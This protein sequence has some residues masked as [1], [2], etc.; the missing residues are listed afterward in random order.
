MPIT[1]RKVSR[2][3]RINLSNNEL[4]YQKLLQKHRKLQLQFDKYKDT[5]E[6]KI[7]LLR[8][9]LK[10]TL[11]FVGVKL[12]SLETRLLWYQKQWKHQQSQ[13]AK[14]S[15][16][17]KIQ[18]NKCIQTNM[19]NNESS[20]SLQ[21]SNKSK[22]ISL[23]SNQATKPLIVIPTP[24]IRKPN[25]TNQIIQTPKFTLNCNSENDITPSTPLSDYKTRIASLSTLN[26]STTPPFNHET[27]ECV[28]KHNQLITRLRARLDTMSDILTSTRD[29]LH[30]QFDHMSIPSSVSPEI[31]P[32]TRCTHINIKEMFDESVDF[33]IKSSELDTLTNAVSTQLSSS[34]ISE[35]EAKEKKESIDGLSDIDFQSVVSRVTERMT[36]LGDKL[37][38]KTSSSTSSVSSPHS[39]SDDLNTD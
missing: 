34:S 28:A 15:K 35:T 16:T 18:K 7:T 32:V 24:S 33:N 39:L 30:Q 4:K 29:K 14:S 11:K 9:Q 23:S 27:S 19:C 25:E 31:E 5:H 36:L 13:F 6:R 38:N 17:S 37:K 12:Q 8:N 10:H 21:T 2:N 3:K 1:S 22:Q 20:K 26:M